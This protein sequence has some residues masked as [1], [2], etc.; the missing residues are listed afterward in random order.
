[1]VWLKCPLLNMSDEK[2][3]Q[4]TPVEETEVG[5][6][7]FEQITDAIASEQS[8]PSEPADESDYGQDSNNNNL[9][10]MIL[11]TGI[12]VGTPVKTKYMIPFIVRANPEGLYIL[13]ISKTL[14][15]IDVAAKFIGRS[16]ISRV[17]V[18][19]AREYGK[20]PVEKFCEFTGATGIFGRFMPGTF[21]NPSLPKYMEPEI[22]I[23][24]DPQADQQAVL[25]AT[26]AGVPVVA[27]SN[28]DNVTSKVDLIIPANN[29]GRKALATVYWL[30]AREVL[31][32]Q[33]T[34]KSDSDM[35]VSIDDFETK[36]V[37]ELP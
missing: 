1:M 10:K 29:R 36:L 15:R 4:D 32:K 22:V 14:S 2:K 9:E 17:A 6:K 21:T 25:E 20:T 5:N 8:I 16:N 18:T 33:G 13:D 37:E 23:V 28:S 7:E 27:I 26:R 31:K 35:K 19:S 24:T 12:R 3:I 11:S 34:I 30:L